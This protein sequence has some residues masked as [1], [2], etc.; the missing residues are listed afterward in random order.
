MSY[1]LKTGYI[2]INVP[3]PAPAGLNIKEI[4]QKIP[5]DFVLIDGFIALSK[6]ATAGIPADATISVAFNNR[7]INPIVWME[8][9]KSIVGT[10]RKQNLKFVP[11]NEQVFDNSFVN[12]TVE[13]DNKA[14]GVY[15][16]KIILRGKRIVKTDK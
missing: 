13:S 6:K 4:S 9:E 15:N 11:L 16:V 1:Q 2:H 7:V 14:G 12:G 10:P 8:A 3:M 5:K